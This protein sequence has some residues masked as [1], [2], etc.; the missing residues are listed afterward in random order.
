MTFDFDPRT[1]SNLAREARQRRKYR[2]VVQLNAI[3]AIL[4]DENGAI[5]VP[6]EPHNY[7]VRIA[8]GENSDGSTQYGRAFPVLSGAGY[9]GSEK[10]GTPVIIGIAHDGE[11]AILSTDR[12]ALVEMGQNPRAENVNSPYRKFTYMRNADLFYALP[13]GTQQTQTM[14]VRVAPSPYIDDSGVHTTFV[15]GLLDLAADVPA[16]DGDG[17]SQHLISAVFVNSSGVLESKTSTATLIDNELTWAVDVVEAFGNRTARALSVRY[18]RLFT[19]HVLLTKADEFGDGRPWITGPTRRNNFAATTAPTV[20]DDIDLRYE[21]GSKWYDVTNDLIYTCIDST[22]DNAIW[23]RMTTALA[24]TTLI[25]DGDS[26]YT[27]LPTDDVLYCNTDGGTITANLP[28]GTGGQHFKIINT[29]TNTLTVDPN[30]TE[31]LYGA[32]AGVAQTLIKGENIDIHYSS[33]LGGWW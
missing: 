17:N 4:G 2:D 29:G 30:G 8:N 33:G 24:E 22:A 5:S 6:G 16:A 23:R 3:Q 1:A 14:E 26:P 32:G 18:Y 11:W 20:N 7:L 21:V 9:M 28:A 13:M 27:I 10:V 15:G 25:D 12:T 19:G 31:E